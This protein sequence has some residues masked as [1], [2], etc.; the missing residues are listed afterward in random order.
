MKAAF[1]NFNEDNCLQVAAASSYYMLFSLPAMMV[2]VVAVASLVFDAT[3]VRGRVAHEIRDVVGD[4]GAQQVMTMLTNAQQPG[5]SVSGVLIGIGTL[6]LG[7]TGVLLQLQYAINT[8]WNVKPRK[9]K[10]FYVQFV[11]KRLVSFAMLIGIGFILIVSL[12]FDMFL[13]ALNDAVSSWLPDG[14]GRTMVWIGHFIVSHLLLIIFIA[15]MYRYL[16][17]TRI[18]WRDV[19]VG[20]IFTVTLFAIGK[21]L[22]ALYLGHSDVTSAY[23]AAGSLA[24]ILLWLFYSNVILLFGVELTQTWARRNALDVEVTA[25]V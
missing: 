17:D 11:I 13:T 20:A 6:V 9:D 2:I 8:A 10:K 22:F 24:L 19:W 16:P 18:E 4:A 12:S 14:A 25:T 23:G 5:E 21:E 3:E 15:G 1:S 7:A